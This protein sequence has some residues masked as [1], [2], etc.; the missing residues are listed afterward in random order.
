MRKSILLLALFSMVIVVT[1]CSKAQEATISQYFEAMKLND[2]DTMAAMSME[3]KDLE[4]TEF[5]VVSIGEPVVEP[6]HLAD[7]KKERTD[8]DQQMKDQRKIATEKKFD[9]DDLKIELEDTRRRAKKDELEAKIKEAEAALQAEANKIRDIRKSMG[10]VKRKIARERSLIKASTN[11]DKN[12][13]AYTGESHT[14][15]CVVKITKADGQ[16]ED[17]VFMLKKYTLTISER[18]RNGRWVI[19]TI[20]TVAD[21]E[22]HQNEADDQ[23]ESGET[24]DNADD[25]MSAEGSDQEGTN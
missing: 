21:F 7:L 16:A 6:L 9:V 11:I 4:Y 23:K 8:L 20:D 19:L 14:S 12:L 24:E 10:A 5:E 25:S 17:F 22:K 2:K 1:S 18:P 15:K 3:P 13:E